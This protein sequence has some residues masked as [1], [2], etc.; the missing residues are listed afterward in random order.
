MS[1]SHVHLESFD[2]GGVRLYPDSIATVTPQT[3][4]SASPPD[5]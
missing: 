2:E 1:G 3:F 5:Q 4:A